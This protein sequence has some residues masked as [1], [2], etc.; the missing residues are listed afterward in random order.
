MACSRSSLAAVIYLDEDSY[1]VPSAC[2][3]AMVSLGRTS[4]GWIIEN[5]RALG[6]API[7]LRP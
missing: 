1:Q 5:L 7:N 3:G 2:L 4:R 6:L